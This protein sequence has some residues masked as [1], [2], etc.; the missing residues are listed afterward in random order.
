MESAAWPACVACSGPAMTSNGKL[1]WGFQ[2]MNRSCTVC[3]TGVLI[4]LGST[5]LTVHDTG[6]KAMLTATESE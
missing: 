6:S 3:T 5:G 1:R 2:S 4:F